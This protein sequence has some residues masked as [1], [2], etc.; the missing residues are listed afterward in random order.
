VAE[1]LRASVVIYTS[2]ENGLEQCLSALFHQD[3]EPSEFEILVVDSRTN[4]NAREM[5]D[6]Y[7]RRKIAYIDFA[8]E[9]NTGN[10]DNRKGTELD[11]SKSGV[12]KGPRIRYLP[13]NK[14]LSKEVS[15]HMA[16]QLVRGEV[17]VFIT[18][19]NQPPSDWLESGIASALENKRGRIELEDRKQVGDVIKAFSNG[20]SSLFYIRNNSVDIGGFSKGG[21][22]SK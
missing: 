6:D 21:E 16:L 13:V 3:I 22:Y 1:I 11:N 10:E 17:I 14:N 18:S 19:Q 15:L 4:G 2:D 7:D 5:V 20:T 12:K 9:G 8:T